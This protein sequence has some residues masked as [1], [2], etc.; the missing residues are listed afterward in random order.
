MT[1]LFLEYKLHIGIHITCP[2]DS[3][4][5]NISTGGGNPQSMHGTGN[6]LCKHSCNSPMDTPSTLWDHKYKSQ[7]VRHKAKRGPTGKSLCIP[8]IGQGARMDQLQVAVMSGNTTQTAYN[9]NSNGG[10]HSVTQGLH[11]PSRG[12]NTTRKK[13]CVLLLWRGEAIHHPRPA[14]VIEGREHNPETK[15][16]DNTQGTPNTRTCK[17]GWVFP[18]RTLIPSCKRME[19]R[20]INTDKTQNTD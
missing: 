20:N 9:S 3:P 16:S 6:P 14:N 1:I 5:N 15:G 2:S 13:S 19:P 4:I 17:E 11:L 8:P 18:P 10:L 7:A 12:V